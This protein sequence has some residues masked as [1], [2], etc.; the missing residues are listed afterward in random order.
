MRKTGRT[1]TDDIAL[2]PGAVYVLRAGQDEDA[3]ALQGITGDGKGH[4]VIDY[5]ELGGRIRLMMPAIYQNGTTYAPNWFHVRD[6][7]GFSRVIQ[8]H[9]QK[10]AEARHKELLAIPPY[11]EAEL[12]T[13]KQMLRA[14]Y[15]LYDK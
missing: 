9:D 2:A 7:N 5:D 6:S 13:I 4:V 8:A 15:V 3:S 12:K 11:T 14:N 10:E 1:W